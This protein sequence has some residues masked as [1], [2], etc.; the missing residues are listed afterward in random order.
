MTYANKTIKSQKY[1]T[2]FF[3][4]SVINLNIVVDRDCLNDK[5]NALDPIIKAIKT[6]GNHPSVLGETRGEGE[7]FSFKH[8][9]QESL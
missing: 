4:N 9:I 8:F 6:Y 7:K 2:I 1:L 3:S 5:V